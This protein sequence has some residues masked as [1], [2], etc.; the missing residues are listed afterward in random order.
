MVRTASFWFKQV[1]IPE[2]MKIG[3]KKEESHTSQ[4]RLWFSMALK[5]IREITGHSIRE[6][7]TASAL[8]MFPFMYDHLCPPDSEWHKN[9]GSEFYMRV[10]L[11]KQCCESVDL[12]SKPL[13][14]PTVHIF[15]R[16]ITFIKQ[17][18][19]GISL[20]LEAVHDEKVLNSPGDFVEA[21][22][23]VHTKSKSGELD[24]F[25]A[26]NKNE[27]FCQLYGTSEGISS[28]L[29]FIKKQNSIP[30]YRYTYQK[31]SI[32]ATALSMKF[33]EP[34]LRRR[35]FQKLMRTK[36]KIQVKNYSSSVRRVGSARHRKEQVSESSETEVE[37]DVTGPTPPLHSA[38]VP[39]HA[40][41]VQARGQ[42][43]ADTQA[44]QVLTGQAQ[45]AKNA[46][47]Q[48]TVSE[49]QQQESQ[50]PTPTHLQADHV[51][52]L[53]QPQANH[54][55]ILTQP[56][57]D[58]G[59]V[60]PQPEVDPAVLTQPLVEHEHDQD[61]SSSTPSQA[62]QVQTVIQ[63]KAA[64]D[65]SK[66][67]KDSSKAMKQ[68]T[69]VLTQSQTSQI[70]LTRPAEMSSI[71]PDTEGRLEALLV[72]QGPSTSFSLPSL[73]SVCH[74]NVSTFTTIRTIV[75]T[76]NLGIPHH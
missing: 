42:G 18:I 31:R 61:Q 11:P 29:D 7:L 60:L 15:D 73:V 70:P 64:K 36:I 27:D 34:I 25:L 33:F 66:A 52:T 28:F 40:G 5:R 10:Y 38:S 51:S 6:S 3:Y 2:E 56:Q 75:H 63:G 12:Y 46:P 76:F 17:I 65:S 16:F 55:P 68:V 43:K 20:S 57:A 53:N 74:R 72:S 67:A 22:R 24:L 41:G 19:C 49:A 32:H 14:N 45:S 47:N 26:M 58:H 9:G 48:L 71:H 39:S 4:M 37:S 69:E 13:S 54:I 59:P 35:L 50:L 30:D 1:P 23:I 62:R 44:A 21:A 8:N